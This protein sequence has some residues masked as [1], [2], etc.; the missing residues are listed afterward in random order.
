[1]QSAADAAA[2]AAANNLFYNYRTNK[3][4]DPGG[5]AAA[6]AATVAAADGFP[7]PT[8][9]IPPISGQ[10]VGRPG[11]AEVIINYNQQRFF[12][13]I[14][15]SSKLSISAR[16][17]ASGR[18][19]APKMGILVLNPTQP[20]SFSMNGGGAA[21]V[22]GAPTI[23]DSNAPNAATTVGTGAYWNGSE[24]DVTGVP[25]ISGNGFQGTVFSGQP[26][27]PDPLAYLP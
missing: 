24:L 1:A 16:A 14:W 7:N 5:T 12:S 13:G 6:I 25:G 9:Y 26:P 18:W 21:I 23:V 10:F 22:T 20:G 27:T 4:L 3:G 8:V 19:S 17:V 2:L 11:Y 15:G